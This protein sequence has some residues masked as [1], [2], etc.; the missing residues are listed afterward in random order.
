MKPDDITAWTG[1]RILYDAQGPAKAKEYIDASLEIAKIYMSLY[2]TT[3]K[4]LKML[5]HYRDDKERCQTA[6]NNAVKFANQHGTRAQI[7]FALGLQLPN[8]PIYS[9]LEGRLPNPVYTYL[10]LAEIT[11]TEEQ[12]KINK[13]IG[14]RRTRLGAK[15]DQVTTAVKAEVY[16]ASN[17]ETLYQGVIDWTNDDDQRV[18][19]ETKKLQRAYDHLLVSPPHRKTMLRQNVVEMAHGMVVI[20]RQFDLAWNIELEW[21]D[22]LQMD[23]YDVTVLRDYIDIFPGTGLSKV[24]AGYLSSQISPFPPPKPAATEL[25]DDDETDG[26]VLLETPEDRLLQMNDGLLEAKESLLAHRLMGAYYSHLEEYESAV[27]TLRDAAKLCLQQTRYSGLALHDT[28]DAVNNSLATALI[29]YQSPKNHPEAKKIFE[30]ILG[31]REH[32]TPALLGVGLVLEE[33]E[34]FSEALDYLTKAYD[35]DRENVR[36]GIEAAWCR[37]LNG[38]IYNGLQELDKF[39]KK[40]DPADASTTQLTAETLYRIGWC[41]WE[42]DPARASRKDRKGPY[43]HFI[44]SVK[45]D[46]NFAPAY[47]SLG[48]YY[49]DY[50]RDKKRAR[51]CFQKAF[52]LSASETLAAERLARLFANQGDW[53]IV[54]AIA[55]RVVDSGKSRPLPGSNKKG[56]SWPHSALG[57]AQ[58]N[59]LE[60]QQAIVSFLAALRISPDDYHSY[61]GLGES[62][63]NSGRYNSALRT[64]RYAENPDD[65]VT[66]KKSSEDWFT[67]YMLANVSRELGSFDE[68]IESYRAILEYRKDEF[69]VEMALMQTLIEHAWKSIDTGIFGTAIDNARKAIDVGTSIL[70]Y[71]P[72]AFNLWKAVSDACSIYAT[73]RDRSDD[74]PVSKVHQLL[75]TDFDVEQFDK[76]ASFD[77]VGKGGLAQLK[78]T[79]RDDAVLGD[80]NLTPPL[81]GAILSAKRAIH[82]SAGDIHA[83]AVA[84]FNLGWVHYKAHITVEDLPDYLNEEGAKSK[85]YLRAAMRSFKRAIELEAGNVDFW[86]SLGMATAKLNPKVAQHS[87]VRSLHLNERNP[88]AWT[89]LGALYLLQNDVELAHIAFSRAQ[90]S[91]PDYAHAW[92]GEG[93][94][95]LLCGDA[96]EALL[97]FVHAFEISEASSAAVRK[98]FAMH[99]FDDMAA[100]GDAHGHDLKT[101]QP[102]LALQQLHCLNSAEL[103]FDH[104]SALYNERVGN[105]A[106]AIASLEELCSSL[107]E[108]YENT[109]SSSALLKFAQAKADLARNYLATHQ[110]ESATV[111]AETALDLTEDGD[112]NPAS[113]EL[114]ALRLSA[115]LTVGLSKYYL[116]DIDEALDAF[117]RLLKETSAAADV[118]CTLAELLWAKGGDEERAV[119]KQQLAELVGGQ[120][121][122]VGPLVLL[123]VMVALEEDKGTAELVQRELEMLRTREHVS[124]AERACVERVLSALLEIF[125][126]GPRGDK[127]ALMSDVQKTIMLHPSSPAGWSRLADDF[128]DGGAAEMALLLAKRSVPPRGALGP[129]ELAEM[130]AR[131]GKVGDAQRA[132]MVAPY[133][134]RGWTAFAE[135]LEAR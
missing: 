27:E 110:Y 11:E 120:G 31:R 106:S 40:L 51:Q 59:R 82:C 48:I 44:A 37:A 114:T 54:E 60:Y 84:W 24:V 66:M 16:G 132:V 80:E 7:K 131:T 109:E 41:Q 94:V 64:F 19:Y 13:E 119:A 76:Y 90:S 21:T 14:E 43:S 35:R 30:D 36:I 18:E 23:S 99:A 92:V 89:N 69:G 8:S 124:P 111:E 29:K 85:K 39:Q 93:L 17:I 20:K 116:Q 1:L 121:D 62:Y 126:L 81:L 97:H 46:V 26:G 129:M 128:E 63:Y 86:N 108:L 125:S 91:D 107:E 34:R 96:K 101:I 79:P 130:F 72:N 133:A 77:G 6:I 32:F 58:M 75:T 103:P 57:V 4:R 117:K 5:R 100:S 55:K 71:K 68:A 112:D 3:L 115:H 88:R 87:F 95:A 28:S 53:D 98:E 73:V 49:E 9:F 50:G 118:I 104:L 2:A 33:E 65:G 67:K 15:K 47:T 135:C 12:E 127:R 74:I 70:R 22:A 105:Y 102:L 42:L 122:Y 134:S 61:V 78:G 123:G 83:Q 38:D 52:D 56:I 45:T 10:R 113:P 25:S